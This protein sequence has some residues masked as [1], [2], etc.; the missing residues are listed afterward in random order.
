[1][2]ASYAEDAAVLRQDGARNA[3][4]RGVAG[5]ILEFLNPTGKTTAD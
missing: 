4:A 5:A 1:M 3:M 2:R